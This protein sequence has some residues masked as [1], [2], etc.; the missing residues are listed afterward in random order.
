[1]EIVLEA[2]KSILLIVL[3]VDVVAVASI[4]LKKGELGR[5]LAALGLL[6]AASAFLLVFL[7]RPSRLSVTPEA[8][9]DATYGRAVTIPWGQV[10]RAMLVRDWASTDYRPTVRLNGVGLPGLKAGWFR[11]AKGGR[12]RVFIQSSGDALVLEAAGT[13]YVY[14]PDRLA[15]LVAAVRE[16]V[17]VEE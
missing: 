5:R 6:V 10:E 7:Y 11:L 8:L 17:T 14:G 12:A 3:A 4:L 13:L 9:V 15:E 16:H 2:P 1:M